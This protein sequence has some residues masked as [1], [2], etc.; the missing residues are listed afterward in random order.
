MNQ[1]ILVVDDERKI[2]DTLALILRSKGYEATTAYNGASALA[3]CATS[4]PDLLLTDVAMPGLNGIQ[5]ALAVTERF[6]ACKVLLF[7]GQASTA[8]LRDHLP[9]HGV[10]FPLISK[11]VH[12]KDLLKKIAKIFSS[13]ELHKIA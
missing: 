2:A 8:E 9:N 11:P 1:R 5:L 6:P 13:S 4:Q 10:D 3:V 7:S 12:P